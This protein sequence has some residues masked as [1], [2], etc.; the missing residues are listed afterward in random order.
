MP[1]PGPSGASHCST[2]IEKGEKFPRHLPRVVRAPARV[3]AE[4]RD[5]SRES[6]PAAV[7][8]AFVQPIYGIVQWNLKFNA[9]NNIVVLT[10]L[11]AKFT[12]DF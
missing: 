5:L 4:T 12:I 8:M 3:L 1:S 11:N 9:E 10:K 2:G 6:S 7:S